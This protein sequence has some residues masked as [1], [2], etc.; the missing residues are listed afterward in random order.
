MQPIEQ[1][2]LEKKIFTEE[3]F[4][5][6]GWHDSLIHGISFGDNFQFLFDI[7]YIF[8]WVL[9]DKHYMFWVSPCTLVF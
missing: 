5:I 7:D 2:H 4:D 9:E 3:D 8:K 1:Y 6:M